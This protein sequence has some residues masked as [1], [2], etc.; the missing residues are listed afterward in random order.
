[1]GA[2]DV[3]S[4]MRYHDRRRLLPPITSVNRPGDG[5]GPGLLINANLDYGQRR[6]KRSGGGIRFQGVNGT[7]VTTFPTQPS[8]WYSIDVTNNIIANNVAGWT[9]A[10]I[11][12]LDA[13]AVKHPQNTQSFPTIHT[14][15]RSALQHSCRS[16][17]RQPRA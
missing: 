6:G 5:V 12:L 2:P 10:G 8:R 13:L 15:R 7:D 1:M 9:G 16:L 11:S 4:C 3:D 17:S 14:P